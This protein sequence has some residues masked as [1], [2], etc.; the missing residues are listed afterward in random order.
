MTEKS[1]IKRDGAKAIKN[2]GRGSHQKGDSTWGNFVVDYKEYP[3]G[4]K[5]TPQNWAKICTDAM[6]TDRSKDPAL[7]I[8]MGEGSDIIRLAV[9]EWGVLEQMVQ[10][11]AQYNAL[12]GY[13]NRNPG[14]Y[15]NNN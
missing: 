3:K 6:R 1:E 5:V 8:I 10:D 4:Y 14:R 12:R 11:L 15:D 13:L 9:I 7:K 2:S